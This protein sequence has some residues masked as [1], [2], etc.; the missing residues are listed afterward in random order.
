MAAVSLFAVGP[1]G[2]L[3]A[4]ASSSTLESMALSI[5]RKPLALPCSI[6]MLKKLVFSSTYLN[7]YG[8]FRPF[9]ADP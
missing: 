4:A 5:K 7:L 3:G 1:A 8:C 6:I 2:L 9:N